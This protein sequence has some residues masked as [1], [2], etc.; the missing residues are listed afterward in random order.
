MF[1]AYQPN[2]PTGTVNLDIDYQN[3]QTNFTQLNNIFGVD[4]TPFNLASQS[5]FHK[6]V[7]MIPQSSGSYPPIPPATVAG[8][9]Q[10]FTALVND[11][12]NNSQALFFLTGG[13]NLR[14]LTSNFTPSAAANGNT[15]MAGGVTVQW[16][17]QALGAGGSVSGTTLFATSNRSFANNC[18]CVFTTLISNTAA[19][20]A[21]SNN[22]LFIRT[23][24]VS[25]LG[26]SWRYNG[27]NSD[28]SGFYWLA[29]GN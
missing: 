3:L 16:G 21:S 17:R 1:T 8:V 5:G 23:T 18:F 24:T 26:F 9:G 13:G 11:G 2:I 20:S 15:F 10:L 6:S 7:H 4:H 12:Y 29:I 28:F 19:G 22:S 27:G 14:Q 25:N